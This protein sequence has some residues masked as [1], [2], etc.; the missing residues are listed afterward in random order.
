[1]SSSERPFARLGIRALFLIWGAPQG[2]RR[3]E[4]MGEL[5]GIDIKHIYMTSKRGRFITPVK[6]SVQLFL[7]FFF[8][9]LHRYQLIFIQDPP[10]F[11]ALPVYVYSLLSKARFVIDSHTHGLLL[12]LW[13]RMLPL[14]R[15][16][17]RRAITTIVTNDRLRAIV[18]GWGSRSFTLEDPPIQFDIPTPMTLPDS[19]LNVVVVCTTSPD[20]PVEQILLAARGLPDIGFYVTGDFSRTSYYQGLMESAPSNVHFTGYLHEDFYALLAA[21]DVV[22]DLCVEEYT[23][24]SGDNEALW[25]G[26]PIIT[27]DWPTL[28]QYFGGGTIFVDNTADDIRQAIMA[29]KDRLPQFEAEIRELQEVRRR[30]WWE[31]AG[32][33]VDLIQSTIQ[34]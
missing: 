19:T 17:E 11:A 10:I 25:L 14:H 12:P 30:Q 9:I 26:K 3:S 7:T 13:K 27:S 29:M 22:M 23:F 24:L 2:S 6:Y 20:E 8:L 1:M 34:R 28:R 5:L 4:F 33:L 15:F 18:E 21:A 16:L 32:S 31:R